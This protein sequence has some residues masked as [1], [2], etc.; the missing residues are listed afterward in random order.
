V[1]IF[2]KNEDFEVDGGNA[3]LYA[4]QRFFHLKRKW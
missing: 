4:S 1:T 3:T 2:M